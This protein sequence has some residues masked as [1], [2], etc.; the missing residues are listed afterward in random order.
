MEVHTHTHTSRKK[1]THYFWEFLMLFLAVTLGFF[2]ENQREHYVEYQRAKQYAITLY[3]DIKNDTGNLKQQI[4]AVKF[5]N[6]R[7]DTFI[8]LVQNYN[9][10]Q[11]P[12]G[13][14]YYFGRFPTRYFD[15]TFQD[16]TLQQ[17]KNSG[18]LR[19]FRDSTVINAIA[20]YDQACRDLKSEIQNQSLIYLELIKWRN[21][22]FNTYFMNEVMNLSVPI[23]KV[24]SFKKRAM[25][26]LTL[27]KEYFIQY[28][29]VCQMRLYNNG[30]IYELYENVFRR[31]EDLLVLL[32]KGYHLK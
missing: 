15:I 32:K 8:H 30:F 20:R 9:P 13:T 14:W 28:A 12:G 27:K 11:I 18:G 16:A 24:D 22:L 25:P 26:L 1:W 2:V 7:I 19:Y 10:Q 21:Q 6:P 17:L 31:G 5:V 29:N 3:E 4:W 23:S